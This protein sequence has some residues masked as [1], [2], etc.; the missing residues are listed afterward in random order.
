[1]HSEEEMAEPGFGAYWAGSERVIPDKGD[2]RYYWIEISSDM[3]FFG[4]APS[5]AHIRDLV[6]RLLWTA[7]QLMSHIYWHS[8]CFIMLRGGR[9]EL[10]CLESTSL[11]GWQLILV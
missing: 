1:L 5:Y 4:H 8:I 11:G 9:V 2:L 6:R 10:S 3:D 7:G